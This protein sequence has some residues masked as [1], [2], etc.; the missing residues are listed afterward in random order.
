MNPTKFYALSRA[1]VEKIAEALKDEIIRDGIID[2][3]RLLLF[4]G[5]LLKMMMESG[6]MKVQMDLEKNEL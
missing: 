2:Q 6:Q 4:L 3:S 5:G 1:P